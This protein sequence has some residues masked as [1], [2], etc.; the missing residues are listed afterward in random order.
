MGPDRPDKVTD[1]KFLIRSTV[2][3]TGD[4]PVE[5]IVLPRPGTSALQ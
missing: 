5:R 1:F 3:K 2:T 4:Y